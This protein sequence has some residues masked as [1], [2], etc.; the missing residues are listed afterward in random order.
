MVANLEKDIADLNGNTS[1]IR[2]ILVCSVS[3]SYQ[4]LEREH[5]LTRD[6]LTILRENNLPFTV[7]TKNAG[8]IEDIELFQGYEKCRVG[9]SIGSLD[10]SLTAKLEP[11]ASPIPDRID[12]L[13]RLKAAGVSTYLSLAPIVRPDVTEPIAVIE[14]LRDYVDLFELEMWNQDTPTRRESEQMI[15]DATG[16]KYERG[17]YIRTL[18]DLIEYCEANR[19]PYCV[20]NHSEPLVRSKI[21]YVPTLL[22]DQR[23]YPVGYIAWKARYG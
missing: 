9:L 10:E 4:P 8:V 7:L 12:A 6:C 21:D 5:R 2:D 15:K 19:V 13:M 14:E 20:A 18:L 22:V 17:W 16:I 11:Y 23:P 3:D 1:R